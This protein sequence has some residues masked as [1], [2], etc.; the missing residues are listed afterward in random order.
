MKPSEQ[1]KLIGNGLANE[2]TTR[3]QAHSA[4][5]SILRLAAVMAALEADAERYRWLRANMVGAIHLLGRPG[6]GLSGVTG[7]GLDSQV[8]AEMLAAPGIGAA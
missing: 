1:M 3:A 7:D 8:D 6:I 5:T 2:A 4:G